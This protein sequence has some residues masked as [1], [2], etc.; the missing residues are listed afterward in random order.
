[1]QWIGLGGDVSPRQS[2]VLGIDL[3]R[4]RTFNYNH[5]IELQ[6]GESAEL[7]T[8]TDPETGETRRAKITLSV[9]P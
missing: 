5:Q 2:R 1:M 7:V 4:F 8:A 3:P 6:D 9:L